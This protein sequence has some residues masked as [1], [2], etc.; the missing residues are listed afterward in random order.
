ML[1]IGKLTDQEWIELTQK[2]QEFLFKD[3]GVLRLGQSYMNA[4]YEVNSQLYKDITNTENDP[5]YE[6]K[7]I[8]NFMKYL[9]KE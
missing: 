8:N 5:F 1:R 6:D 4:L 9:L 3:E 7:L 2:T